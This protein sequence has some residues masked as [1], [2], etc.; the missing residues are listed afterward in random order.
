MGSFRIIILTDHKKHSDQNSLYPLARQLQAHENCKC[1]DIASRSLDENHNFFYEKDVNNLYGCKVTRYFEYSEDGH[2]YTDNLK[3]LDYKSYDI[4]W[5]RL[6]RPITD[7]TLLWLESNAKNIIINRPSGI[8]QTSSKAYLI[9]FPEICPPIKLVNSIDEIL[10]FAQNFDIVLKPLKEYGGK[11][12]LKIQGDQINDGEK[13]YDLLP[14]LKGIESFITKEGYLAMKFLKNVSQGDKRILVVNGEVLAASLRLPPEGSWLC[15]VAQGGKSV[16]TEVT[17]EE[18]KIIETIAPSLLEKGIVIFG[19][20]T[21]VDDN[22]KRILSEINTLSIGGFPQA[23][24]QT[25]KPI[26]KQTIDK[27]IEYAKHSSR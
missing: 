15:N 13:N 25:G 8:L 3:A 26:I 6:A 9:N 7:E 22:G 23:E 16:A 11:G 20:D 2:F 5:L 1:L 12:L 19:A 14:Y 4:V 27:F 10:A 24:K 21:L 18:M 17:N